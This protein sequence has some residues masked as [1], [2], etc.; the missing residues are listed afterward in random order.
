MVP[1]G[2]SLHSQEP[3]TY[4]WSPYWARWI[5]S[6]L[7]HSISPRPI[8]ILSSYLCL[9]LQRCRYCPKFYMN[10]SPLPNICTLVMFSKDLLPIRDTA[11]CFKLFS[12]WNESNKCLPMQTLLQVLFKHILISLTANGLQIWRVV[13]NI[14][15]KQLQRVL[16][17]LEGSVRG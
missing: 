17:Q 4:H 13:V 12:I 5:Q 2:S 15:N 8:L 10:F 14:L 9:G 3:R 1:K 6:T 11:S 7:S 16:L